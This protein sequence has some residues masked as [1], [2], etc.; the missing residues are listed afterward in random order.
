MTIKISDK[1]SY[2]ASEGA[3]SDKA[4]EDPNKLS[5]LRR[6]AIRTYKR[7]TTLLPENVILTFTLLLEF[8][9]PPAEWICPS[10]SEHSTWK[11]MQA[12]QNVPVAV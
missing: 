9:W 6:I 4:E 12:E 11:Q 5:R 8:R 10:N 2:L 1:A 3:P 7:N